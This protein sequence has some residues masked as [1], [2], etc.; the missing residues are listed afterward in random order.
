MTLSNLVIR[1]DGFSLGNLTISQTAGQ[2]GHI[3]NYLDFSGV[4]LIVNNFNYTYGVIPTVTG[5]IGVTV[6]EAKLFPQGGKVTCSLGQISAGYNFQTVAGVIPGTLSFTVGVFSLNVSDVLKIDASN[7]TFDTGSTTIAT[8]PTATVTSPKLSGV[9]GSLSNFELRQTGFTIGNPALTVAA[10]DTVKMGDT[11]TLSGLSINVQNFGIDVGQS[12]T[13][14]GSVSVSANS[15]VLF[16]NST[17]GITASVTSISG[18]FSF[19]N[20]VELFLTGQKLSFAYGKIFQFEASNVAFSTDRDVIVAIGSASIA[21]PSFDLTGSVTGL[22]I[23]KNAQVTVTSLSVSMGGNSTSYTLAKILPVS[24]TTVTVHFLGDVNNNGVQDTGE[25]FDMSQFDLTVTGSFDFAKLG[26]LPFTPVIRIG[27]ATHTTTCSSSADT[28]GFTLRY[29]NGWWQPWNVS[30]IEIGF[31]NL[32]IKDTVV[33]GGTINLGSFTSGVWSGV[34]SGSITLKTDKKVTSVTGGATATLTGTFN[35]ATGELTL[36]ANMI[37]SFKIGSN[38]TIDTANLT[39]GLIL[40]TSASPFTLSVGSMSFSGTVQ[41]VRVNIADN[42]KFDGSNVSINFNPALDQ[43]I[44]E[45]G[46]AIAMLTVDVPGTIL[47]QIAGR[48]RNVGINAQGNLV[49]IGTGIEVDL[50][51]PSSEG[52]ELGRK[53]QWPSW[54]PLRV[55]LLHIRWPDFNKNPGDF[56]MIVSGEIDADIKV[57]HF[58]GFV[59]QAVIDTSLYAKGQFPLVDLNGL[60]LQVTGNFGKVTLEGAFFGALL[61]LDGQGQAIDDYDVVTPVANRV[62]YGGILGKIV[63]KTEAGDYG[64]GARIGVSE[65]GLLQGYIEAIVPITEPT[66]GTYD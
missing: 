60:G 17:T 6:T 19:G 37:A 25:T 51:G 65:F 28:F 54:M 46:E 55:T 43:N 47:I 49:S 36:I 1:R 35:D 18:G 4:T 31:E 29:T 64:F 62:F 52:L 33:L 45:M 14:N 26:S 57:L 38:V 23:R 24:I 7:V 58:Q 39:F 11:F 20:T 63:V 13:I 9:S 30:I 53:V 40:K 44:L 2:T 66:H 15:A 3:G 42:L 21:I 10:G 27:S 12:L 22:Q 56:K 34:I 5:T 61:R 8:I 48:V 50:T 59:D 16:P 32:N 41:A